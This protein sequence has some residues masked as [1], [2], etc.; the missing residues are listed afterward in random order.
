MCIEDRLQEWQTAHQQKQRNGKTYRKLHIT[1]REEAN[2]ENGGALRANRIGPEKFTQGKRDEGHGFGGLHVHT[3][4]VVLKQ[5]GQWISDHGSACLQVPDQT[6]PKCRQHCGRLRN[7]LDTQADH[8]AAVDNGLR[9]G[10]RLLLH[11]VGVAFFNSQSQRR[12]AIGNEV[13]PQQLNG[14][15]AERGDPP[16]WQGR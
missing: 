3:A 1:I 9:F 4:P 10:T 14:G 13:E 16:A 12:R 5:I 7:G 6:Q 15:Q 2:L 8:H 11:D